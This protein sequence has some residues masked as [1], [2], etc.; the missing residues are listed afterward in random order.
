MSAP[1]LPTDSAALAAGLKA[2]YDGM[3]KT[4]MENCAQSSWCYLNAQLILTGHP[5]PPVAS[6]TFL[7]YDILLK[8]DKEVR[9]RS[10]RGRM[11]YPTAVRVCLEVS[12]VFPIESII[13]YFTCP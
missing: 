9:L 5:I 1:S 3:A 6:I 7:I 8:F 11:T 13:E 4:Y 12:G 10:A 2:I